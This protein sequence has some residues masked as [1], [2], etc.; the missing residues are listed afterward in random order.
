VRTVKA[1]AAALALAG[2][3]LL[4]HFAIVHG[5]R[6]LLL[7]FI[8]VLALGVV[9]AARSH[10]MPLRVAALAL[11]ALG[12]LAV[13]DVA[14]FARLAP[15]GP[16]AIF[17]ALAWVFG[18]T[19]ARGRTPLIERISRAERG[20]DLPA[21]LVPYT[22]ALTRTWAGVLAGVG[23]GSIALALF[24]SA[25]TWSLFTNVLSYALLVALFFGEYAYRRWRYPQYPHVNPLVVAANLVRRAPEVFR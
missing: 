25:E 19:L 13:L 7:A 8:G 15:A 20:G 2:P 1:A 10:R 16:A 23:L 4:L 22:R 9:A 12:V 11:A 5:S 3:P 21:G 6:T 24:G 18:R 17:L 14:A